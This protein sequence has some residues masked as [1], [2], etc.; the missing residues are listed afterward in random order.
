MAHLEVSQEGFPKTSKISITHHNFSI[1]EHIL[2]ASGMKDDA[3]RV[4]VDPMDV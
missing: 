4:G 1:P 2:I 3:T